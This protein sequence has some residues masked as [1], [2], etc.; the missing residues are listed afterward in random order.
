MPPLRKAL[1]LTALI[2]VISFFPGSFVA[3]Q[4]LDPLEAGSWT[5]VFVRECGPPRQGEDFPDCGSSAIQSELRV[6]DSDLGVTGSASSTYIQAQ[7]PSQS[8]ASAGYAG[9]GFTPAISAYSSS[10]LGERIITSAIVL[11]RYEFLAD[12]D[13]TGTLV[14]TYSQT[15]ID[16]S[17]PF[18]R[19]PLGFLLSGVVVFR[20]ENDL[21]EP[22]KCDVNDLTTGVALVTCITAEALSQDQGNPPGEVY[23]GALE[24]VNFEFDDTSPQVNATQSIPFSITGEVDDIVFLDADVFIFANNGGFGDSRTTLRIELDNPELVQA[25]FPVETFS[26]AP[27]PVETDIKPGKTPNSI[28]PTS[29]QKIPVAILT[30]DTFDVTQV[31][32]ETVSVGPGG[33]TESHGR[34]HVK[35]V[36]DDGDMDLLLHFD[37]PD[38]GIE[39][40]DTQATLTGETFEGEPIIGTDSIVTVN[41]D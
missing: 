7:P 10:A 29:G 18:L 31:D 28:N 24:F 15:G 30:T 34:A 9:G 14:L 38:T 41:C 2:S 17:L 32:W 40:G 3:A 25:S 27:R 22:D 20:T 8:A 26:H 11:Q 6:T 1:T 4:S 36:D 13:L 33:A 39:C 19:S 5:Q 12:G 21:F 35:D 23:D 37:I 16:G